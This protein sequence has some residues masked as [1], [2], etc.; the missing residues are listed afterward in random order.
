LTNWEYDSC[1]IPLPTT[2]QGRG[3]F[4][5]AMGIVNN[6][7]GGQG[8]ELVAVTPCGEGL[9]VAFFKRPLVEER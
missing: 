8:W 5:T 3:L 6:R 1:E 9:A 7:F 2:L 4:E